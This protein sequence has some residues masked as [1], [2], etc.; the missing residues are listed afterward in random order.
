MTYPVDW[1][2]LSKDCGQLLNILRDLT[3]LIIPLISFVPYSNCTLFLDRFNYAEFIWSHK[4]Q[5]NCQ[6]AY[7]LVGTWQYCILFNPYFWHDSIE[8]TR[9]I[10]PSVDLS[11][12]KL[13]CARRNSMSR[14]VKCLIRLDWSLLPCFKNKEGSCIIISLIL[15]SGTADQSHANGV[16]S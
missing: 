3:V 15:T 2:A 1:S 10:S 8:L 7:P 6:P 16:E 14:V 11:C 9:I 5:C 4:S 13:I 12:W